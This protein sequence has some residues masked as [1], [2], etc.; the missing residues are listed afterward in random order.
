GLATRIV[1]IDPSPRATLRGLH[2]EWLSQTVPNC[3]LAPFEKLAARDLLF[4]D[5]SHILMPGTDVDFLFNEVLPILPAGVLLHLH[6]I[7]LPA[8]YRAGWG[9]RGYNDQSGVAGL[10]DGRWGPLCASRYVATRMSDRVRGS[11]VERLPLRRGAFETSLWLK[12]REV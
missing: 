7:F 11:F 8:A 3:G 9:G 5:S 4:V 1:A 2:L 10:L 6:D 12:R